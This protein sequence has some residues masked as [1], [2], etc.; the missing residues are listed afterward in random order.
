L[1]GNILAAPGAAQ[2]GPAIVNDGA[3]GSFT[4]WEDYRSGC[5]GD[6]YVQHLDA[7]GVAQCGFDGKVVCGQNRSQQ[8]PQICS[9]GAGGAIIAWLDFRAGNADIYAQRVDATGTSLWA[10]DGVPV[11]TDPG[12]L[13]APLI[14]ACQSGGAIIVWEDRRGGGSIIYAQKIT[15]TGAIAP[16]WP[17]DGMS[18]V[19][20]VS[21]QIAPQVGTD[22]VKGCVIAWQD[23]RSGNDD[24]YAQRIDEFAVR[25]W[26]AVG[27]P[28][29]GAIGDQA[30][31]QIASDGGNGA[32]VTWEDNRSGNTD[33]YARRVDS[34][35]TPIW[36]LDGLLVY[37][38][39]TTQSKPVIATDVFGNSIVS[40]QDERSGL[41]DIYAQKIS[42]LGTILWPAAGVGVCV[43][44]G[45]QQDPSIAADGGGGAL[46]SW[47]DTRSGTDDIYVQRIDP[48]GAAHC[49]ADGVGLCV[50][51]DQQYENVVA[52]DGVGGGVVAWT[53][54]RGTHFSDIQVYAMRI[55]PE[56]G[57]LT[58]GVGDEDAP[59]VGNRL[60]QN[61]P[62]PFNPSTVITYEMAKGGRVRIA[63]F[64]I[65]GRLIRTLV[66]A[67]QP[68]GIHR[69]RWEG[70][71][72]SGARAASG[73]YFYRITFPSGAASTKKMILLK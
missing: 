24:I 28:V 37:G 32:V 65:S 18:A 46:L 47:R 41:F 53:D 50:A 42:P 3:G 67:D 71:L 8:S 68:A 4:A 64:D 43:A 56:C 44:P 60:L 20:F 45:P 62:N 2:R 69:V 33:V 54:R 27:V 14:V 15:A 55:P 51:T 12:D 70:A 66:N 9:D 10:L 39:L 21:K 52:P 36:A 30:R 7:G 29:C 6:I 61:E 59:A 63:L 72:D 48:S 40:W 17:L 25:R 1:D 13:A 16:G 34:T 23:H 11:C 31:P 5:S 26:A 49:V 35:G 57:S 22:N 73:A 38:D 19:T 58:T